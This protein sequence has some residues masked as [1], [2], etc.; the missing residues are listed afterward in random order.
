M[1]LHHIGYVVNTIEKGIQDY[2]PLT[3]PKSASSKVFTIADQKVKVCFL[4]ISPNVYLELVEPLEGN[5]PLMKMKK[6]GTGFYH[7]GFLVDDIQ[8]KIAEFESHNYRNI[9]LFSSEAFGGRLCAFMLSPDLQL[10]EF[11]EKPLQ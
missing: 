7:L 5:E 10:I 1:I 4:E 8:A 11:I 3:L 2:S 9:N 6:R